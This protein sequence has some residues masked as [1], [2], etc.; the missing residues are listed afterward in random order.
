MKSPSIWYYVIFLILCSFNVSA[1]GH[2]KTIKCCKV[3]RPTIIYQFDSNYELISGAPSIFNKGDLVNVNIPFDTTLFHS[4]LNAIRVNNYKARLYWKS[5]TQKYNRRQ[6]T[7]WTL[8][9]TKLNVEL[10]HFY[11]ILDKA[12]DDELLNP[13]STWNIANTG[14]CDYEYVPCPRD[15]ILKLKKQILIKAYGSNCACKQKLADTLI[16]D[17]I[18]GWHYVLN[19]DFSPEGDL[20]FDVYQQDPIKAL[21][22]GWYNG[23]LYYFPF[24]EF[25]L[26]EKSRQY[27]N[28]LFDSLKTYLLKNKH[29]SDNSEEACKEK[30]KI[31]GFA[32]ALDSVG[33]KRSCQDVTD[34]IHSLRTWILGFAWMNPGGQPRLN[35]FTFTNSA[36]Y[37]NLDDAKSK[38][39]TVDLHIKKSLDSLLKSQ[40]IK[41]ND[42][43][44]VMAALYKHDS[45]AYKMDST[46]KD[47]SKQVKKNAD[48]NSTD[49]NNQLAAFQTT[50]HLINKIITPATLDR[51]TL[52]G[53]R[54]YYFNKRP[55][56]RHFEYDYPENES[57]VLSIYNKPVAAGLALTDQTV[58]YNEQTPIEEN[59][60]ATIPNSPLA[61]SSTDNSASQ[62]KLNT[63]EITRLNDAMVTEYLIIK[64]PVN[65]NTTPLSCAQVYDSVLDDFQNRYAKLIILDSLYNLAQIPPYALQTRSNDS[66]R[67]VTDVIYPDRSMKVPYQYSYK[68]AIKDTSK[69]L[70]LINPID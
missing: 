70:A 34:Q 43:K 37:R 40:S 1:Q 12:T 3:N 15:V 66:A 49:N 14:P 64:K 46:A 44:D 2:N 10:E 11:R 56:K 38:D 45:L 9:V 24:D 59:A 63:T 55:D 13:S 50:S 62:L 16:H 68:L 47:N 8:M 54:N 48:Q 25:S 57:V 21:S 33:L 61:A 42:Y 22:I 26:F 4:Q 35:P 30:A 39:D 41:L 58:V 6:D 7:S 69:N 65:P 52:F 23:R 19:K 17:T 31:I 53:I 60:Q 51:D 5:I 27:N 67:F 28:L 18:C 36:L 29:Y 32:N 20:K